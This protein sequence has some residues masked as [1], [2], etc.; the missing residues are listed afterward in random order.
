MP[1]N[2]ATLADLVKSGYCS[3]TARDCLFEIIKE[4][5]KVGEEKV[6]RNTYFRQRCTAHR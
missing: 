5:I 3:K 4:K 1:E 2:I 6:Y